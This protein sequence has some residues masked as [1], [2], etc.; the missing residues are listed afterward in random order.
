MSLSPMRYKDFV[1]PHNPE[2]YRVSFAR[3]MAV[4]PVP[5]GAQYMQ[6]L[7][8][9][10]R[11]MSGQGV[12]YGPDAY[13]TFRELASVF[14]DNWPGQLI[15]P[16]WSSARVWFVELSLTQEPQASFVSY[17]FTFWEDN[18]F[19]K[20]ALAPAAPAPAVTGIVA[21]AQPANTGPAPE[22]HTVVKGETLSGIA[23]RYGTT[24]SAVIA[25]NP[26]IKN[27]NL[28]H[29]GDRVRVK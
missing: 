21:A 22:Y 1:W 15:H 28:I 2:S 6:G 23:K 8:M 5:Y 26:Q 25:L 3:N 17:A 19:Y 12:F 10:H 4:Q 24:L 11:V 9:S 16:V 7:S 14:Y 29:P 27:P 20:P 18:G 13:D